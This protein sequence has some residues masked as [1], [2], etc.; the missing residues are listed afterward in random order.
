MP[1]AEPGMKQHRLQIWS[2]DGLMFNPSPQLSSGKRDEGTR[3]DSRH[4]N[5]MSG[6]E[7]SCPCY[8]TFMCKHYHDLNNVV[9][10]GVLLATHQHMAF[11]NT[12]QYYSF[13]STRGAGSYRLSKH[14][15]MRCGEHC[16]YCVEWPQHG[17]AKVLMVFNKDSLKF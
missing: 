2:W 11:Q 4:K 8:L 12:K 15:L 3:F 6:I 1:C 17:P 16:F 5:L 14:F 9:V 13:F 7:F 10:G